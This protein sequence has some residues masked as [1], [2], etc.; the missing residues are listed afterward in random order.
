MSF[1]TPEIPICS[2]KP[3]P[4]VHNE[5]LALLRGNRLWT[6]LGVFIVLM[7]EHHHWDQTSAVLFVINQ[8][9]P[10]V[11]THVHAA[12]EAAGP[13]VSVATPFSSFNTSGT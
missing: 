6:H 8:S 13:V 9:S 10:A 5:V 4:H 7:A 12:H 11:V 3:D 1:S 2:N